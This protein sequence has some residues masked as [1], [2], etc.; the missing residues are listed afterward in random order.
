LDA[1]PLADEARLE[2]RLK[3]MKAVPLALLAVMAVVFAV[4]FRLG[5]AAWVGYL[6]A[7]A[8]AAMVGALADWFAVVALFRHPLGIPIPHTAIV[9]RRKDELA[10]SLA[11]FVGRHF[12]T[13][14]VVQRRLAAAEPARRVSTWAREHRRDIAEALRRTLT[15]ALGAVE[16]P[17]YREFLRRNVVDRLAEADLAPLAGRFLDLLARNRHHLALFT[18]GLRLGI[19]FLEDNRE[20]IR[21]Q[22]ARGSPWWL[23]GFVDDRIYDQMIERVQTQL[24]A[25]VLDPDHDLRQR[26]DTAFEQLATDLQRSPSYRRSLEELKHE[27]LR[28]PTLTGYLDEAIERSAGTLAE[29]LASNPEPFDDAVAEII[30]GCVDDVLGNADLRAQFDAWL[31][32]AAVYLVEHYGKALTSVISDTVRSWDATDAARRIE[33]QVGS[34][35]QFIRINGTLVGG[36]CGLL[37]HFVAVW[38]GR[39]A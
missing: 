18:E 29:A 37:I 2:K 11:D 8:E 33:L 23:P 15:W 1:K 20:P 35:L 14:D 3:R 9:P 16:L 10:D 28:N 32:Q 19:S 22:I 4:S 31:T 39:P 5:G 12:L 6:R 27:L 17:A 25:M 26:F 13:G 36:L 24:L 7:F 34:D 30:E 38:L 21:Q